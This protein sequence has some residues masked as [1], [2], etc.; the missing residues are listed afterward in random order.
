MNT[1]TRSLEVYREEGLFELVDSSTDFISNRIRDK[2]LKYVYKLKYGALAPQP[3]EILRV[4]PQRVKYS[5]SADKMY[6]D[7]RTYPR[8]GILDGDWDTY[9]Y[10]W[11]D[12]RLWGGLSERFEDGKAWE[13]TTYYQSSIER[14]EAGDP[15]PHVDGPDTREHLWEYL[16]ELDELYEDI[17]TNGYDPSSAIVVHLGRNGEWIVGQGNHRRTIAS[18]VGVD[19]IPVRIR[20]RHRKWQDIRRAFYDADSIDEIRHLEEHLHHTDTPDV[21][22]REVA[23][24][25]R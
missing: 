24:A 16:N 12:S 11:Q 19:S 9:K 7:D 18:I 4:D 13:D 5:T 2:W 8:F 10:R 21:S 3:N 20:F 6:D 25:Q 14:L 22:H 1:I 15:L 17:Q 23:D